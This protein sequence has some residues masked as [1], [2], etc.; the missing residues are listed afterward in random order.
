MKQEWNDFLTQH[1][2]RNEGRDFG[3]L[4]EELHSAQ[5]ATILTPLTDIGL[6]R[7][8]GPDAA[9]FLHNIL[10]NDIEELAKDDVRRCGFCTPKGRLLASMMIWHDDDD[11]LMALSADIHEATL[12]KLSMYVL[13]SKVKLSD[14]YGE[15]VLLG[16]SGPQATAMLDK[17][18]SIPKAAMQVTP[19]QQGQ[20]IRLGEMRFILVLNSATAQATWQILISQARPAGLDAWHWLEIVAGLPQ[21]TKATQEE[22]LPQMINFEMIGGVS[23][24]KGCYPGQEIVARTQYLG[25]VKRRMYRARIENGTPI[26]GMHLYAPE[27]GEQSCGLIVNAA[28]APNNSYEVLAAIQTSCAETGKVHLDS[29]NGP[30][31]IMQPLPYAT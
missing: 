10:T 21:I 23:F 16:L 12:K 2:L 27:T 13:R 24:K 19:I 18:G 9:V 15:R 6:I 8:S 14:S 11:L 4:A 31:L 1:G 29:P 26:A 5:S 7:A 30:R 28:P 22:F 25:K 17:L 3:N 20:I